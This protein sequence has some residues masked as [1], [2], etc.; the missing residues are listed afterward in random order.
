M[1]VP[2][3]KGERAAQR[4]AGLSAG[5]MKWAN[6][7]IRPFM[8]DQHREF[9][10]QLAFAVLATRSTSDGRPWATVIGS[11]AGFI[12]S[13]DAT[14]LA[15]DTLPAGDDPAAEGMAIGRDVGEWVG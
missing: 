6:R 13:P 4:R 15:F 14:H 2:W 10:S 8:P 9:Y 3:H 7:A 11:S 12:S 5:E 1:A